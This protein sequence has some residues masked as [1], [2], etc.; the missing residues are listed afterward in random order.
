MLSACATD[1]WKQHYEAGSGPLVV[2]DQ[3][4]YEYLQTSE[5]SKFVE[6]LK[7]RKADSVLQD[8]RRY[9]V[10]IPKNEAF[11]TDFTLLVDSVQGLAM[12]NHITAVDVAETSFKDDLSLRSFSGKTLWMSETADGYSINNNKINGTIAV[13]KDGIIYGIDGFLDRKPTLYDSFWDD[14]KYSV[15]RGVLEKYVDT[16]FSKELSTEI[17][18]DFE[19]RPVYDS[20]FITKLSILNGAKIDKDYS[21]YTLFLTPN[22]QLETKIRNYFQNVEGITGSAP[23]EK[24]STKLYSF[25]AKSF[26]HTGVIEKE[27][28]LDIENRRSTHWQLWKSSYQSVLFDTKQEFS[29][30]YL[31]E[32]EDLFIPTSL[33][34]L[35]EIEVYIPEI[36]RFDPAKI[37][38]YADH[39]AVDSIGA[40]PV[41][42]TLE[43]KVPAGA[44]AQYLLA[45]ATIP[46]VENAP[47]YE[48][49]LSWYTSTIDLDTIDDIEVYR[50]I[51]AAPGE[52]VVQMTFVKEGNARED[53]S[54]FINDKYF[55]TV[56]MDEVSSFGMPETKTLGIL[57]I[58]EEKGVSPVKVTVKNL[59]KSWKRGLAPMS[60]L[61]KR[62][63]NNY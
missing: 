39:K 52:Y 3:T 27:N 29:N 62:T 8:G 11:P 22:T 23:T 40:G 20:V 41:E 9:T 19:G 54:V 36:Y 58:P 1:E 32:M 15:M 21:H 17:G 44:S 63:S 28:Y 43:L 5:Y 61:F 42:V 51:A 56:K 14:A 37:V 46:P 10:W 25:L 18:K 16:L 49:S 48:F 47:V 13:C 24:D 30:G 45:R 6:I 2:L 34:A 26:I 55:T 35:N 7:K 12:H 57:R 59:A 50:E 53:F 38:V 60:I 33:T 31:Y 4:V